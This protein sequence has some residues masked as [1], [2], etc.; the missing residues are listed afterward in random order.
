MEIIRPLFVLLVFCSIFISITYIYCFSFKSEYRLAM[1]QAFVTLAGLMWF[2]TE[3]LSIFKAITIIGLSIFWGG[4]FFITLGIMT[5]ISDGKIG[6]V[7]IAEIRETQTYLLSMPKGLLATLVFILMSMLVLGLIA[8]V[9]APN[10]WDSMT[11]HLSR[12]MHWEQNQSLA[13]YPTS[14]SRQL[15]LGPMAEM[16]ILNFQIL[17]GNDHLVN[18]VQYFAMVGGVVGISLMAYL[19]GGNAHAQIFAS[20]ATITLPMG[21][22][23]STSTQN[24]YVVALWLVCFVVFIL[25]QLQMDKPSWVLMLFAGASLGL[26]ILTKVTV[27]FFG[28]PFGLWFAVALIS[29]FKMNSWRF[30]IILLCTILIFIAPHA[31]RNYQLYRNP[32]GPMSE[33]DDGS[34]RYSN[35]SFGV[36]TLVSNVLRNAAIHLALPVESFNEN[37]ER[38]ILLLHKFLKMDVD[39]PDTTWSGTRFRI[40]YSANED[41][42]GNPF[43]MVLIVVTLL[44]LLHYRKPQWIL[45]AVCLVTGFILFSWLI[46]WQPWHSRLHLPLFVLAIPLVGVVFAKYQKPWIWYLAVAVLTFTS[47]QYIFQNPTRPLL[48]KNSILTTDRLHQYFSVMPDYFKS[49]QSLAQSINKL[50]CNDIGL[51]MDINDWEYPLWILTRASGRDIH[52]EHILVDNPSRVLETESAPCAIVV[53]YPSREQAIIYRNEKFV[54]FWEV[55]QLSLFVLEGQ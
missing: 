30:L 47:L 6:K 19:L 51:M 46:K 54:K 4:I 18:F 41:L 23:Q 34:Y 27:L 2:I 39:D 3:L 43:H 24:D 10:T 28:F 26:A 45:F 8:F 20:L 25:K 52:F 17:A 5:R 32:L 22:L 15:H 13:F 50:E 31:T 36:R 21:I 40:R 49:Y 9:A 29:R 38:A 48:G 35:E 55:N 16:A 33:S 7:I 53:T 11:Y 14:I 37:V 42:A 44:S 12:V 1:L